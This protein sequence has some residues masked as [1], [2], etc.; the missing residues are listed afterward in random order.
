MGIPLPEP[1][2]G[3]PPTVIDFSRVT[4]RVNIRS[5]MLGVLGVLAM[6]YTLYFARPILMPFAVAV[7][8]SFVFM[9]PVR[10]V[11]RRLKL[12]RS[13]SAAIV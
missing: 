9:P 4:G 2:P 13:A 3:A 8:L 5:F 10:F 11:Q 1:A 6:M 12:P 7:L